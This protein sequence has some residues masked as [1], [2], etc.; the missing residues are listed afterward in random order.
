MSENKFVFDILSPKVKTTLCEQL[1]DLYVSLS[2]LCEKRGLTM[3]QLLFVRIYLTD[4]ANQM[5]IVR[6]HKLYQDLLSKAAVSY[7]EQPLLD[8]SKVALN[9]FFL[10][11]DNIQK[12]GTPEMMK[13]NFSDG[14]M[15]FHA[16][17][18]SASEIK[19][20]DAEAQTKLAFAKHCAWLDKE[21]M[22]LLNDCHRTWLYVRDVD[23]HYAGV[24][25]GRN[26][27]FAEQ[28]LTPSTHFITS[29]GIE[30]CSDDTQAIVS[31]DFFSVAGLRDAQ[32]K[33]LQAL[34][35]LNPTYEY[36]V[37]FERGTS[38]T[39]ADERL[40]FISGTA[41]IDKFGN[42][43]YHGDV[44]AQTE[45]LFLNIEQLLAD[46]GASPSDMKYLI[47]YLR[48]VADYFVVDTYLKEKF[49]N[50]PALIT[51]ARVCRP[52]WLIE[53]ETIAVS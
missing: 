44:V 10:K 14:K 39:L 42:C 15:L 46:G 17:R 40:H 7:I 3:Q 11:E 2:A 48:D 21:G 19:G 50:V 28:G 32:V 24:V 18:F 38:M 8:S 5:S 26:E 6:E 52:E 34:E 16:V 47:V 41:S 12:E 22:T 37:A 27:V 31:V 53:V 33:Y 49:P 9:L 20:M 13:V 4:A 30:G 35:Y 25:K 29:T 1:D 43:L 23:R 51:L 45:R 36:G